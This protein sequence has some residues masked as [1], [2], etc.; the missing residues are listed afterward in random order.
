[1]KLIPLIIA[2]F[3]A[4]CASSINHRFRYSQKSKINL[5]ITDNSVFICIE[6]GK[7]IRLKLVAVNDRILTLEYKGATFYA[8]VF[9]GN[10]FKPRRSRDLIFSYKLDSIYPYDR[11]VHWRE[12]KFTVESDKILEAIS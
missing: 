9:N 11:M 6:E 2:L 1:M 12:D 10:C 3:C 7:A 4:S 5:E 8:S